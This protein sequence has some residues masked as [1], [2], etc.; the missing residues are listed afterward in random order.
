[1][2]KYEIEITERYSKI[3][4]VQASS[5]HDA[6]EEIRKKYEAEDI[7]LNNDDWRMVEIKELKL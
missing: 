4:E 2:D 3:V 7:V 1:M 6:V 5:V